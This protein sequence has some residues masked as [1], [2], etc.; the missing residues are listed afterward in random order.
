MNLNTYHHIMDWLSR[1]YSLYTIPNR[2]PIPAIVQRAQTLNLDDILQVVEGHAQTSDFAL[3]DAQLLEQMLQGGMHLFDGTTWRVLQADSTRLVV[4]RSGYFHGV[5]TTA[6]LKRELLQ[7]AQQMPIIDMAQLPLRAQ[8]EQIIPM[9]QQPFSGMGRSATLG[10]SVLTIFATDHGEVAVLMRR[11][12][13]T[14]ADPNQYHVLPSFTIEPQRGSLHQQVILEYVEECWGVPEAQTTLDH[15]H[16]QT[17]TTLLENGSA[18]LTYT[19]IV[20][21]PLTTDFNV[22]ACLRIHDPAIYDTLNRHP[23]GGWEVE[24]LYPIPLHSPDVLHHALPDDFERMGSP[25]G[26]GSFWLAIEQYGAH[27]LG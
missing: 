27:L 1:H 23:M 24:R 6:S 21:S 15:P 17:L 9:A 11:S 25:H 7:V 5:A 18:S 4:Q 22:A 10:V 19:G 14:A 26:V 16:A 20:Y 12:A 2:L 3:Y 8:L 13:H